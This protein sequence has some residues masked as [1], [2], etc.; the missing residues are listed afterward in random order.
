MLDFA[1]T[2]AAGAWV[3]ARGL[4]FAKPSTWMLD[5]AN[6]RVA[7]AWVK[8]RRLD[9]A[10][11]STWMLDFANTRAVGAWVGA[12]RI[13]PNYYKWLNFGKRLLESRFPKLRDPANPPPPR[14]LRNEGSE[15]HVIKSLTPL[16]VDV[17]I[18]AMRVCQ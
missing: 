9:F 13:R 15:N 16:V 10:K 17:H 14:A 8:A 11:P 5:F 3:R 1:N 12:R 7:G 18:K 6:T 4:S 2:M